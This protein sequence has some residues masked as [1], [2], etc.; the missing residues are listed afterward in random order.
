[1][2]LFVDRRKGQRERESI[3]STLVQ[4]AVGAATS[5]LAEADTLR[6]VFSYLP[7]N[8]LYLGAVCSEWRAV[9]ACMNE[10]QVYSLNTYGKKKVLIYGSKTTLYSAAVT[11]PA[12]AWRVS[13]ASKS[14]LIRVYN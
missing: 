11:S 14:T 9:Y 4:Q 1:L 5:P 7:G 2:I 6:Q 10:Q 3:A 13:W 8:W 12:T